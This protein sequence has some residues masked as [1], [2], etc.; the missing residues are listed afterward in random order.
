M[1][2]EG[3]IH[4]SVNWEFPLKSPKDKAEISSADAS[5]NGQETFCPPWVAEWGWGILWPDILSLFIKQQHVQA[6]TFGIPMTSIY[7]VVSHNLLPS[8]GR[9]LREKPVFQMFVAKPSAFSNVFKDSNHC[10]HWLLAGQMLTQIFD[11]FCF[12]IFKT[13]R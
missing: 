13:V 7:R 4:T 11:L 2:V 1:K 12:S 9:S 8:P 6:L 5:V 10:K 3:R